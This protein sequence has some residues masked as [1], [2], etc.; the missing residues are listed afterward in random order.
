MTLKEIYCPFRW[1]IRIFK[2]K[3]REHTVA[4]FCKKFQILLFCKLFKWVVFSIVY[5]TYDTFHMCL[6]VYRCI[7]KLLLLGN[8]FGTRYMFS[9]WKLDMKNSL[10]IVGFFL[11]TLVTMLQAVLCMMKL[12]EPPSTKQLG[13]GPCSSC[14]Y[15]T[16]KYYDFPGPNFL[17]MIR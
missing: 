11:P 5:F 14:S 4:L 2:E 1:C 12:P 13:H 8:N 3:D 9:I 6:H 7:V 10:N 16:E 15:F 17:R